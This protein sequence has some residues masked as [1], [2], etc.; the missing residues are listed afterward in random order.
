MA[1]MGI[2]IE[3]SNPQIPIKDWLKNFMN[4]FRMGR[5][6]ISKD[7]SEMSAMSFIATLWR[8]WLHRN[9]VIFRN[10]NPNPQ[11]VMI[12]FQ[13]S[14]KR[15]GRIGKECLSSIENR[16]KT[17]VSKD[18]VQEWVFGT[19][20]QERVI[21]V[22]VDGSWKKVKKDQRVKAATTWINE[23]DT[24]SFSAKRIFAK[25]PVQAE[26]Y[27]VMHALEE[28]ESIDKL[29][30]QTDSLE[31]VS[32][33]HNPERADKDIRAIILNIIMLAKKCV[34]FKCGK[35]SRTVIHKAHSLANK[36]RKERP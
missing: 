19:R 20:S 32:A 1:T 30:I 36:A 33:L 18:R 24:K 22:S 21:T 4:Y 14:V 10:A 27:A 15:V 16:G 13:E 11:V 29:V 28:N 5:P 25:S 23:S 3:I 17:K 26:A 34:F 12:M 7:Q 31:V 35:S 9:E 8:I 6:D 2:K